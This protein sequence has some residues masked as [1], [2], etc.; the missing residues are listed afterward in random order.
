LFDRFIFLAVTQL[1]RGSI[2]LTAHRTLRG[3][4][5]TFT[6]EQNDNDRATKTAKFFLLELHGGFTYSIASILHIGADAMLPM[7]YSANGF[8][9]YTNGFVTVNPSVR[10]R[11]MFGNLG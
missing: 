5:S 7:F 6:E 8:D 9:A 1:G 3:G 11:F 4:N 10:L 2:K